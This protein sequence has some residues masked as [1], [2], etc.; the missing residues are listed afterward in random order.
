MTPEV[1]VFP[2]FLSLFGGGFS[3]LMVFGEHVSFSQCLTSFSLPSLSIYPEAGSEQSTARAYP[4]W[5]MTPIVSSTRRPLK[6]H[7]L[8]PSKVRMNCLR[9]KPAPMCQWEGPAQA[10]STPAFLQRSKWAF[11]RGLQDTAVFVFT[12]EGIRRMVGIGVEGERLQES[13]C[14]ERCLGFRPRCQR[15]PAWLMGRAGSVRNPI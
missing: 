4:L 7:L 8:L 9:R 12:P 13:C 15:L 3:L 1:I 5:S 11:S 10:G 2:L 6:S 14:S